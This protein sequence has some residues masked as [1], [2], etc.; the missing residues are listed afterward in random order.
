MAKHS[1]RGMITAPIWE[2]PA[3]NMMICRVGHGKGY[4]KCK[5]ALTLYGMMLGPFVES[6][7]TDYDDTTSVRKKDQQAL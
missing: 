4:Q 5:M 6:H 3:G 7:H 1:S 2:S